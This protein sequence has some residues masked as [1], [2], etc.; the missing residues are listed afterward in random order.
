M[1][2]VNT[3]F[4]ADP[5]PFPAQTAP[6]TAGWLRWFVLGAVITVA[7]MAWACLRGYRNHDSD[8]E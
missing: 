3:I 7:L 8:G 4:L 1:H 6:H 2:V 5:S